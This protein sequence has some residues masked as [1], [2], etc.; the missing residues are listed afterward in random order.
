VAVE[1]VDRD[2]QE[3]RL[4]FLELVPLLLIQIELLAA[5]GTPVQRVEDEDYRLAPMLR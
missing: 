3:L 5:A 2:R 1:A 4:P